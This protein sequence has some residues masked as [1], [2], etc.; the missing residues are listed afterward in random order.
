M[1]FPAHCASVFLAGLLAGSIGIPELAAQIRSTQVKELVH[2]DLASWC[3]GKEL[4]IVLQESG[5]GTSSRHYHPG[6]SYSYVLAGSETRI[7]NGKPPQLAK[8]GDVIH[9]LPM[10]IG[11]T[12]NTVAVKLLVVSILE[13]GQPITTRVP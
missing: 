7:V 3:P 11:E 8:T 9:E 4:S 5:P 10:E 12:E 13:K 6:H 2:T 1:K